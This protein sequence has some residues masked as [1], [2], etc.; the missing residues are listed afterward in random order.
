MRHGLVPSQGDGKELWSSEEWM[1]MFAESGQA[2][3]KVL[4]QGGRSDF[5]PHF[6]PIDK[7]SVSFWDS[8]PKSTPEKSALLQAHIDELER[9]DVVGKFPPGTDIFMCNSR[10]LLTP[11]P[12]GNGWR[13]VLDGTTLNLQVQRL[14]YD[15]ELAAELM[16]RAAGIGCENRLLFKLDLLSMFHQGRLDERSWYLTAFT[17]PNG[18]RYHYKTLFM[19]YVNATAVMARFMRLVFS[20]LRQQISVIVDDVVGFVDNGTK[21]DLRALAIDVLTTGTKH[22]LDFSLAKSE[23]GGDRTTFNGFVVGGGEIAVTDS[24]MEAF[25]S[26]EPPT[27]V[28]DLGTVLG[29]L[30]FLSEYVPGSTDLALPLRQLH[31]RVVAEKRRVLVLSESEL[32]CF[33]AIKAAVLNPSTLAVYNPAVPASVYMDANQFSVAAVIWQMG[34]PCAYF[35]RVL[36]VHQILYSVHQ[37]EFLTALLLFQRYEDWFIVSRE[38]TI[39]TDNKT[40][41][42]F[43]AKTLQ[44]RERLGRGGE[45]FARFGNAVQFVWIPR[46]ENKLA[47]SLAAINVL[48]SVPRPMGYGPPTASLARMTTL[49]RSSAVVDGVV[50]P[51]PGAGVQLMSPDFFRGINM[52]AYELD[53]IIAPLLPFVL[54]RHDGATPPELRGSHLKLATGLQLGRDGIL[55]KESSLY[56]NLRVVVPVSVLNELLEAAH[57]YYDHM[58]ARQAARLARAALLGAWVPV[59]MQATRAR[60][61]FVRWVSSRAPRAW[62]Q[63]QPRLASLTFSADLRGRGYRSGWFSVWPQ[64]GSA[65]Y[66]RA[67]GVRASRAL[68]HQLQR[69]RLHCLPYE[70]GRASVWGA[71]DHQLRQRPRQHQSLRVDRCLGGGDQTLHFWQPREADRAFGGHLAHF[72]AG[73]RRDGSGLDGARRV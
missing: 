72:Y 19:G 68:Q 24:R 70:P 7:E 35:G 47:D 44:Q 36:N 4:E 37:K 3:N 38:V 39:Y 8:Q 69:R 41:S 66:G 57:Y 64:R 40:C 14:S 30:S 9:T 49:P 31:A 45:Y 25:K 28:K 71:C 34:R 48:K 43:E 18:V 63:R 12:N 59:G 22:G 42:K 58:S 67:Y 10:M 16:R 17:G 46:E 60:V 29:I 53:P 54:A 21:A 32:L 15:T 26:W 23:G 6:I 20:H 50:S 13:G 62:F 27:T 56:G 73:S 52:T 51:S 2:G 11:K 1:A 33:F 55:Y 61:P 65:D 5:S